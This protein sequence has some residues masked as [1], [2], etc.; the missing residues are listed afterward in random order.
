[1]KTHTLKCWPGPF[2][3]VWDQLKTYEVRKNDR[4]FQVGDRLDLREWQPEDPLKLS[5]ENYSGRRILVEVTY[6]TPGGTWGLPADVCVLGIKILAKVENVFV[7]T[8]SVYEWL[9]CVK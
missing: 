3:A 8:L 2:Q 1:M 5:I 6:M 9:S 4:S 7:S